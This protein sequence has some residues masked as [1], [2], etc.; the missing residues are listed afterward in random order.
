MLRKLIALCS[1]S[2]GIAFAV[3]LAN[4]NDG[5]SM[6]STDSVNQQAGTSG[7]DATKSTPTTP[8]MTGDADINTRT[9]VIREN[10]WKTAKTCTDDQGVTYKR[11]KKGF[12]TCVDNMRRKE[13]MSGEMGTGLPGDSTSGVTPD[14]TSPPSS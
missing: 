3:A 13:Q 14:S 12:Q 4:A 5:D 1:V 7:M 11:G 10:H 9:E 2:F 8:G 6:S